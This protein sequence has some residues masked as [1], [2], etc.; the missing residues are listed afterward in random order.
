MSAMAHQPPWSVCEHMPDASL[1]ESVVQ[2]R[3]SEHVVAVAQTLDELH[4]PQPSLTPSLQR[5][6]VFALQI[7]GFEAS[8][9]WHEFAGLGVPFA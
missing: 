9:T 2:F 4:T 5:L 1:Q 6:P 7:V 3:P 8:Q